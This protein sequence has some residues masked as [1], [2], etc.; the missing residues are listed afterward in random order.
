MQTVLTLVLLG[1]VI[2]L[3]VDFYRSQQANEAATARILETLEQVAKR[4]PMLASSPQFEV[5]EPATLDQMFPRDAKLTDASGVPRLE[6]GNV[7]G[8]G[9]GVVADAQLEGKGHVGREM[10]EATLQRQ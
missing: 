9:W 2:L 6:R 5:L 4:Q 10:A 8:S 1:A 7:S 3:G